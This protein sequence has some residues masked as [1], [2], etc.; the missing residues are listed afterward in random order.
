MTSSRA[1]DHG[2]RGTTT[3]VAQRSAATGT[4]EG[5]KLI[6]VHGMGGVGRVRQ[7][8][9][10]RVTDEMSSTTAARQMWRWVILRK[11]H[12]R[13]IWRRVRDF[14]CSRARHRRRGGSPQSAGGMWMWMWRSSA[15]SHVRAMRERRAQLG[16][17]PL[18]SMGS[19]V[20]LERGIGCSCSCGCSSRSR[21]VPRRL[22]LSR[23]LIWIVNVLML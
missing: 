19:R 11:E 23:W 15:A 9:L 22:A 21:C 6:S 17:R 7:Y 13:L 1:S 10:C 3:L 8:R 5:G 16:M 14:R 18:E 2:G 20:V 4:L 12:G